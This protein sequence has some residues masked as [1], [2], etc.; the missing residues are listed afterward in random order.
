ML[1]AATI[2]FRARINQEELSVDSET[3]LISTVVNCRNL[4][5]EGLYYKEELQC[6]IIRIL[7]LQQIFQMLCI[8]FIM[9]LAIV[10]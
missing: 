7:H 2:V 8:Q 1:K 5:V 4:N 10:R 6:R 3:S 9:I